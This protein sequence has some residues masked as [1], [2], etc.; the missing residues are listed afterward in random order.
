MGICM[1]KG[2]IR[3]ISAILAAAFLK[4][5]F[6]CAEVTEHEANAA[7]LDMQSYN[8]DKVTVSKVPKEE[9]YSP[10]CRICGR[11]GIGL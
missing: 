10:G 1:K 5:A 2:G 9:I 7:M 8:G 4:A 3:A 11:R 6:P